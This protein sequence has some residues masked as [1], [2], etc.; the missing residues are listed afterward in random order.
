MQCVPVGVT[1]YQLGIRVNDT[2]DATRAINTGVDS[3]ALSANDAT[4]STQNF[5]TLW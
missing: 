1:T 5:L 2:T 3:D 4:R